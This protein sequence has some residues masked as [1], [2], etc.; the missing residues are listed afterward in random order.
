MHEL[1]PKQWHVFPL[2]TTPEIRAALKHPGWK[3]AERLYEMD[4]SAFNSG[5]P[6]DGAISTARRLLGE[7]KVGGVLEYIRDLLDSGV[8]KL[9]VAAWHHSV[10]APLRA[11][12]EAHGLVYMDGSTTPRAK[13]KAVDRFQSEAGIRIILGQ[14]IPLGEGWTL[15]AAQDVV[16]A[17]P[18]WVPGKNDQLLDRVHRFGQSGDRVIGHVPVVP[19]SMDEKI[20]SVAIRKDQS[21]HA[22][23]DQQW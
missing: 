1:P 23:L 12:L 18:D 14:T 2:A 7:A 21:I 6:V 9:V 22:A 4:A 5:I 16:M 19:G 3:A 17:E 15:T 8:E 20:F 11:G 13:Q 10:L